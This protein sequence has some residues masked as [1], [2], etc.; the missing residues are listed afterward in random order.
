[1]TIEPLVTEVTDAGP[2]DET[3]LDEEA[4]K[5]AWRDLMD[6]YQAEHGTFTEEELA[7]ARAELFG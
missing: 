4:R 7:Q 3:P 5:R 1:M 2:E 6:E